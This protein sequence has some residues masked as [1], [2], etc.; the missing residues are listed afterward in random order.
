MDGAL[1]TNTSRGSRL[2][3][4]HFNAL[5]RFDESRPSA[6][7]RL[8]RIVGS[9]LTRLLVTALAGDHRMRSRELVG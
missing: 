9:R 4:E 1:N 5:E 7:A 3:L 6:L 8:E 2:I